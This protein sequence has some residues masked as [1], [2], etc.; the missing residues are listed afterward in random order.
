M[1]DPAHA[2][3]INNKGIEAI[4]TLLSGQSSG[5]ATGGGTSL[6]AFAAMI[7]NAI[8]VFF[9]L[10]FAFTLYGAY[11]KYNERAELMEIIQAP[12]VLII[13]VVVIDGVAGMIFP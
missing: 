4:T 6:N 11:Q 10:I 2:L 13:V 3:I 9:L 7:P 8:K 5:V 1:T 12:V